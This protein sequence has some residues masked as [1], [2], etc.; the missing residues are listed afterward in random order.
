MAVELQQFLIVILVMS[1]F[2]L[3]VSTFT[4]DLIESYPNVQNSTFMDQSSNTSKLITNMQDKINTE[5]EDTGIISAML[6]GVWRVLSLLFGV[7]EIFMSLIRDV[8]S[9]FGLPDGIAKGFSAIFGG[10]I[11]VLIIFG[12][13]YLVMN[14]PR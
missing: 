1:A 8:I 11:T 10:I 4:G 3:G 13:A 12:I 7:I 14:M 2:I 9:L 5:G 6:T